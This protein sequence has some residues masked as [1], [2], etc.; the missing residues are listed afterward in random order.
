MS[1][2]RFGNALVLGHVQLLL[3][4]GETGLAQAR[5]LMPRMITLWRQIFIRKKRDR[6]YAPR[7]LRTG[8]SLRDPGRF[9]NIFSTNF[10]ILVF[11]I[12]RI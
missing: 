5:S 11:Q 3:E 6:K 10:K 12:P 2:V 7:S 9:R 4:E 8:V 1:E